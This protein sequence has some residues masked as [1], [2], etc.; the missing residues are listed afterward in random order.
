[1]LILIWKKTDI[2][3][4]KNIQLNKF[5]K[6]LIW[7]GLI[8]LL[9]NFWFVKIIVDAPIEAIIAEITPTVFKLSN[10]GPKT[11]NKPANVIKKTN[12]IFKFTF[13]LSINIE[14]NKTIIGYVQKIKI[15]KLAS[16]YITDISNPEVSKIDPLVKISKSQICFL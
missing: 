8:F 1:M 10:D 15:A 2:I 9:D 4:T 12:L 16:I 14:T 5:V 6:A 7:I 11:K 3:V 13:S